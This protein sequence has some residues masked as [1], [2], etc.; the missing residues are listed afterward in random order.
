MSPN[1][2]GSPGPDQGEDL[3]AVPTVV[4]VAGEVLANLTLVGEGGCRSSE[5][6]LRV[7]IAM[8]PPGQLSIRF[9]TPISSSDAERL[10]EALKYIEDVETV[11]RSAHTVV[12]LTLM[13]WLTQATGLTYSEVV[14][15]LA[16][17]VAAIHQPPH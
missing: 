6:T 3:P 9:D 2:V 12:E 14:Q 10:R 16:R 11:H 4:D 7:L 15:D 13:D 8:N 17:R 5:E 1:G